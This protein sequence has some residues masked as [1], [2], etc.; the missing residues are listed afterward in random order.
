MPLAAAA[1]VLPAFVLLPDAGNGGGVPEDAG[2]GGGETG[3]S[4][5]CREVTGLSAAGGLIDC[6]SSTGSWKKVQAV[7]V[8]SKSALVIVV[9]FMV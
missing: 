6:K 1:T 5:G 4:A 7:V 2:N 9:N 8:Q 3:G